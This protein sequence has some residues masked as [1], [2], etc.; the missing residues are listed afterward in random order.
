MKKWRDQSMKFELDDKTLTMKIS[1]AELKRLFHTSPENFN[2]VGRYAMVINGKE[3]EFVEK[4]VNILRDDAP[5]E[6]DDLVWSQ[7]FTYAFQEIIE[8]AYD[9]FLKYHDV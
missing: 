5:Y 3:Q 7:M 4:I 2:G 1:I 9:E 6:A 8:G